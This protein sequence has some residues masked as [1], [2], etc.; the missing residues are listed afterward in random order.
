[1]RFTVSC[2]FKLI[3]LTLFAFCIHFGAL[4]QG[5]I[6]RIHKISPT[7]PLQPYNAID[8]ENNAPMYLPFSY[9]EVGVNTLTLEPETYVLLF[10]DNDEEPFSHYEFELN[11]T[12]TPYNGDGSSDSSYPI[13]LKVEFN[14]KGNVGNT[15]DQVYHKI[16]NRYGVDIDV[17]SYLV[18]YIDTNTSSTTNVPDNIRL[19]LGYKAIHV[20]NLAGQSAPSASINN[21]NNGE[22]AIQ[23]N[24]VYGAIS[25]DVEWTWV[26]NYGGVT[27]TMTDNE[28]RLN[29]TRVN[30]K[31]TSY[32]IPDIYDQGILYARVRAVGRFISDY[33][34]NFYGPWSNGFAAT[35]INE[36]DGNKNWQFQ[37]SYAEEG[38]KKE[39]VSYFDGSLRNRQTVTKINTD[40]NAIVGEVIYDN[41]GRPAI[42]ILPV[43]DL[44]NNRLMFHENFNLNPEGQLYS[45]QDFD[46]DLP[47]DNP[48]ICDINTSALSSISGAGRYYSSATLTDSDSEFKNFV[49]DA[50]GFPFSQIEYTP[51]NTGR[52]KRKSGVGPTHQ[53]GTQHEMKYFYSTPFQPELDRLFGSQVGW[54]NHYKKNAV[55]DPN[56]QVSVSYIDPQGRTIATALVGDN[57]SQLIELKNE[58]EGTTLTHG[59]TTQDLLSSGANN[60]LINQNGLPGLNISNTLAYNGFKTVL[61]PVEHTFNYNIN[62]NDIFTYSCSDSQSFDYPFIF[63]LKVDIYDDCGNSFLTQEQINELSNTLNSYTTTP[64]GIEV[65]V[66]ENDNPIYET[67]NLVSNAPLYQNTFTFSATPTIGDMGIKKLLKVN[68]DVLNVFADDYVIKAQEAGCILDASDFD[69]SANMEDCF[70]TCDECVDALDADNYVSNHLEP[71]GTLDAETLAAL[72]SRFERELELLIEACNAPCSGNGISNNPNDP[73]DAASCSVI[74]SLLLQDMRIVGQYGYEEQPVP[75]DGGGDDN[76]ITPVLVESSVSIFNDQN[77]LYKDY[78]QQTYNVPLSFNNNYS[79]RTPFNPKYDTAGSIGHYYNENGEIAMVQLVVVGDGV[80]GNHIPEII[81]NPTTYIPDPNGNPEIAY[82]EPWELK[83]FDTPSNITFTDDEDDFKGKWQSSWAESLIVFHPEYC[84]VDYAKIICDMTSTVTNS[85]NVI[86]HINPDGFDSFLESID[87]TEAEDRGYFDILTGDNSNNQILLD[88]PFFKTALPT[89]LGFGPSFSNVHKTKIVSALNNY[90][91]ANITMLNMA[92]RNVYCNSIGFCAENLTNISQV[93][94]NIQE[95]FWE[96][97][98]GYYISYK[99]RIIQALGHSYASY[100]DCYNGCIEPSDNGDTPGLGISGLPFNSNTSGDLCDNSTSGYYESKIRR[101]TTSDAIY[102]AGAGNQD[103]IDDLEEYTDYNY[104]LETGEC[105]LLRDF[106]A[107]LNGMVKEV[108]V[109]NGLPREIV[110]TTSEPFYGNYLSRGLFYDLITDLGQNNLS[111]EE[112]IAYEGVTIVSTNNN[113]PGQLEISFS[114]QPYDF[115]GFAIGGQVT[116]VPILLSL[117]NNFTLNGNTILTWDDYITDND[118]TGFVFTEIKNVFYQ[119]YTTNP[120]RF[121]FLAIGKA[122][123]VVNGVISED[124]NEVILSGSTKARIGECSI[125]GQ[126]DIAEDENGNPIGEDLGN[127][128]ALNDEECP[129]KIEFATDLKNIL[130]NIEF[131]Q[132]FL[133]NSL[134]LSS[135]GL[136]YSDS[137][138][139]SYFGDTNLNGIWSFDGATNTGK[140]II[141]GSTVYEINFEDDLVN[142]ISNGAALQFLTFTSMIIDVDTL[143]IVYSYIEATG[144]FPTTY[145]VAYNSSIANITELDF[146]CCTYITNSGCVGTID[147][148]M[149]G[150]PDECDDTPCGDIDSDF[151]GIFDACDDDISTPDCSNVTCDTAFV[152]L[153]NYLIAQPNHLFDTSFN[154]TNQFSFYSQTCLDEFYQIGSTDVLVWYSNSTNTQF[155]LERNGIPIATFSPINPNSFNL[156]TL[157]INEFTTIILPAA[158]DEEGTIY[159]LD[160]TNTEQSFDYTKGVFICDFNDPCIRPSGNDQDLDGIDDNCDNCPKTRNADQADSDNDGIGDLCDSCPDKENIGDSDGD[161]I[162]DACDNDIDSELCIEEIYD[163]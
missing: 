43:P 111:G 133:S 153:L 147:T 10:I 33:K 126:A 13:T 26:D 52:I 114:G 3:Y 7:N 91:N 132:Q 103:N 31:D 23:W 130:T 156:G 73:L 72:T 5:E 11:L 86:L 46:W 99:N 125:D 160:S 68:N 62:I 71:Y 18:N 61:S 154:L 121:E 54:S 87:F 83:Y 80:N 28:F 21:L 129:E 76:E 90:E 36:H 98:R 88:D 47:S 35:P 24:A 51:D 50:Q 135:L 148:D 104:Y 110:R 42:E 157:D 38:K 14:P 124:Y 120:I 102:D 84:Y 141:N 100:N 82:I 81:N 25:Y 155:R 45:H 65:G 149:D 109:A 9:T 12:V 53:L 163:L 44:T 89:T 29:S 162:D 16:S 127:G 67:F 137:F 145:E 139:A 75:S 41:Q 2:S 56:G 122:H 131:S 22:Y 142:R 116:T 55:I 78:T 143:E 20:K 128:G 40:D 69:V 94:P 17:D 112:E 106:E 161:G 66:D 49:P 60:L 15:I 37:A 96:A 30:T 32:K 57:P 27:P 70:Q 150:T 4:A 92:F 115:E 119:T 97:Y 107:F 58:G 138:L 77:E 159:Y 59:T 19:R 152:E 108:N 8:I 85:D 158:N 6:P 134:N 79:W 146:Q 64:T 95:A 105:P 34:T 144:G 1:M 101:Y 74:E 93:T 140:I 113:N 151:D 63:D 48:Q 118:N 136:L 117:P 123:M 39:V